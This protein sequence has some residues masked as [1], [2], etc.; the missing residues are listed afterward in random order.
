MALDNRDGFAASGGSACGRRD[1]AQRDAHGVRRGAGHARGKGALCTRSQAGP[2][3]LPRAVPAPRRSSCIAREPSCGWR[4]RRGAR[5]RSVRCPTACSAQRCSLRRR[6]VS[7]ITP[8][9][10]WRCLSSTQTSRCTASS[11]RATG[12][13]SCRPTPSRCGRLLVPSSF[14]ACAAHALAAGGHRAGGGV[15]RQG[16]AAAGAQEAG[17][18]A[19]GEYAWPTLPR[20]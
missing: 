15:R 2:A 19:G 18:C 4:A 13:S 17:A 20:D 6:R 11:R 3:S 16:A 12:R 5:A 14:S 9:G 1:E 8:C 10:R 7:R